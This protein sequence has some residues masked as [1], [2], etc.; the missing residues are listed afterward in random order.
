MKPLFAILMLSLTTTAVA[1][2]TID[3]LGAMLEGTFESTDPD[4]SFI[5]R[6]TRVAAPELGDHVFYYQLND[7]PDLEVYRQRILVLNDDAEDGAIRQSAWTL[8]DP[9]P[10]VDATRDD[11]AELTLEQVTATMPEGCEQVWTAT[12]DGFRGYVDPQRC[13]IISSRTGKPRKIEAESVL[14]K[15]ALQLAER[16]FDENDEQLFGTPPGELMTLRRVAD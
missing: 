7:G 13:T 16:G 9:E 1:E 11:F 4:N 15:D 5:D 8:N 10:F 3:K 6:R 12:D 2:S 14:T